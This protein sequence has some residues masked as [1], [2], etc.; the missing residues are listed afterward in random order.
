MAS[1]FLLTFLETIFIVVTIED[2]RAQR[3]ASR[4]RIYC[5]SES[6]K[7]TFKNGSLKS[8]ARSIQAFCAHVNKFLADRLY[9]V[10]SLSKLIQ[11]NDLKIIVLIGN[12]TGICIGQFNLIVAGSDPI[13]RNESCS[14]RLMIVILICPAHRRATD[15]SSIGTQINT[16]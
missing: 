13:K 16:D 10:S 6:V 2:S 8:C 14:H 1:P 12:R 15:L 11:Q 3:A 9:C 5:L 7:I 4:P